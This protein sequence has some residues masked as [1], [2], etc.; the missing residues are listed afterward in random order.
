MNIWVSTWFMMVPA[1]KHTKNKKWVKI[2]C[3]KKNVLVKKHEKKIAMVRIKF[4]VSKT[5]IACAVGAK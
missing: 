2:T 5:D 4:R 3:K 1:C